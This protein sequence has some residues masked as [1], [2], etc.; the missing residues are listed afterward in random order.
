M[1]DSNAP[2]APRTDAT[3]PQPMNA[4]GEPGA[5]L[6]SPAEAVA[7]APA[8]PWGARWF[9]PI[10]ALLIAAAAIAVVWGQ[11]E[12]MR[13]NKVL[14]TFVL[15]SLSLIA[16]G[17]WALLLAGFTVQLRQR[18]IASLVLM[19]GLAVA[20][21]RV[22]GFSGDLVPIIRLRLAS[23]PAP[24]PTPTP[25]APTSNDP[26]KTTAPAQPAT[27]RLSD[28]PMPGLAD[29]PQFHGPNRDA[30]APGLALA[31]DW[32]AKPPRKLWRRPIEEAWSAFAVRGRRAV[33]QEQRGDRECVSCYD[34]ATGE[35]LWLHC[36]TTRHETGFGGVGPRAT[37]TLTLDR[38]F[39]LGA[40]GRLNCLDLATGKLI[41]THDILSENA[42][43]N[44]EWGMAGSP[45]LL[46]DRVIVSA[47]GKPNQSL[48]AYQQSD[49]KK[50]WAAGDSTQAYSSPALLSLAGHPQIVIL[51]ANDVTGHDPA[52]G[53]PLW[54]TPWP[55]KYPKVT[56][57]IPLPSL[58]GDPPHSA[59]IFVT[60]S[61]GVGSAA[62]LLTRE[63]PTP[64]SFTWTVQQTW[65]SQRIGLKF[66][67]AVLHEGHV[68]GLDD[69]RLTCADAATGKL[70]S[71]GRSTGDYGHGQCIL[72][73]ALADRPALLLITAESGDVALVKLDPAQPVELTRFS[74]L[75]GK[76]WNNP[77]LAGRY[78]LVRNHR[79]AAC[80]ELPLP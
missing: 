78:L 52:T 28:A 2:Q 18:L 54:S 71:K 20:L 50:A 38:A 25:A 37:P 1:Q 72:L 31:T 13:Q 29:Y 80:Y 68:Y 32:V 62:Y 26:A 41:W 4:P 39:T 63:T 58:T 17:V 70:I 47:G 56:T 42:S 11:L 5:S 19:A 57:P 77:A 3:G 74:A 65:K 75:E 35:P 55:G 46:D 67:N 49:G 10:A 45:L 44:I 66:S 73:P 15:G 53:T 33:T 61:Y 34:V 48:V 16:C 36:D 6:E 27:P 14:T 69:G 40:N 24:S 30:V 9:I 51:N 59:R 8:S 21:L 64:E 12:I 60:S 43:T 22:D 23:R 7:S 76:T 79:E